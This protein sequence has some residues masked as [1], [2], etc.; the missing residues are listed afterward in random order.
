MRCMLTTEK[1][2]EGH[3]EG[4][5]RMC[6]NFF[7]VRALTVKP[8]FVYL[9]SRQSKLEWVPAGFTLPLHLTLPVEDCRRLSN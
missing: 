6:P 1:Q 4:L 7:K 8:S 3:P 5:Q 9:V 2:A